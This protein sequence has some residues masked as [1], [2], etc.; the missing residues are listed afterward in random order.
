MTGQFNYKIIEE[1]NTATD[2]NNKLCFI[3]QKTGKEKTN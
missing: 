3:T 1:K 2:V